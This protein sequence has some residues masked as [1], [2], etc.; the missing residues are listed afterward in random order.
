MVDKILEGTFEWI[1]TGP[2]F[3]EYEGK[4][5]WSAVIRPTKE[6]LEIVR[7]MQAEGIKNVVKKDDKGYYVKFSKPLEKKNKEGKVVKTFTTPIIKD[8]EGTDL[9]NTLVG[10]GSAGVMK[11][12]LY[13]HPVKGGKTSHAARFEGVKITTLVPYGSAAAA[14]TEAKTESFF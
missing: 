3:D 10:N 7:D 12:D 11:V 4:R 1:K 2:N 13:E 9:T 8:A 6:S 5:S 14:P